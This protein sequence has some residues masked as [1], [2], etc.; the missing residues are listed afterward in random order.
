MR[1]SQSQRWSTP[2]GSR[3]RLSLPQAK[4]RIGASN[5]PLE[6]EADH[7]ADKVVSNQVL[8]SSAISGGFGVQRKCAACAGEDK[9]TLRLQ[10]EG[11]ED[12]EIRMKTVSDTKQT[13]V[14][15]AAQNAASAI[16]D[17]GARLSSQAR[18]YFE[19]RFGRDLSGV[20]IHTHARAQHAASAIGARAYTLGRDIAFGAGQYAPQSSE[21]RHLLAHELTH[22]I[23]QQSAP[24]PVIRRARYGAGTPPKFSER[25]VAVVPQDER[26]H[27][28]AAMALVD[29]VV[30]DPEEFS[31][32]HDHFADRCPG[33]DA[34]TLA[35]VW[36]KAVIWRITDADASELAQGKINGSHVA[37][38]TKGFGGS[39]RALASTLMHE[40]GHNCGIPNGARH[41]HAEQ[42]ATY[43]MGAGQNEISLSVG[44]RLGSEGVISMLSYRRFLGDWISGRLRLTLGADF[45]LGGASA[46]IEAAHADR[47]A[48]RRK[49]GEFGSAMV[50]AQ[51]RLGGFGGSRFG[52]IGVRLETGFGAGRFALR[53]ATRGDTA[54]TAVASS[55]VLQVGPKAEFLV[56][57]GSFALPLSVG[58]AYR[59]AKPLNSDAV[60]LHGLLGTLEIRF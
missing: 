22:V 6:H 38:T 8:S 57:I 17:G 18:G 44:G 23:Q 58:A 15:S 52:G 32:C 3:P 39:A 37:F 19:P 53:P 1:S 50:G 20:R 11:E 59:L 10:R 35:S 24:D 45:N 26:A 2:A 27:V 5:D 25:T 40:A 48:E 4:L 54:S 7:V 56:P 34:S 33:G 55:W 36:K 16:V 31:E 12:D 60:A 46:E 51:M 28:D 14:D 42:V 41:W 49:T 21:G 47:P 29:E 30:N 9:E 13:P 43:C